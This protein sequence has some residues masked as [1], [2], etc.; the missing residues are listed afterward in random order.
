[1]DEDARYEICRF[2]LTVT[3]FFVDRDGPDS[4]KCGVKRRELYNDKMGKQTRFR[5]WLK[6]NFLEWRNK[7]MRKRIL[8]YLGVR[9]KKLEWILNRIWTKFI[10]LRISMGNVWGLVKTALDMQVSTNA[11]NLSTRW[12][13]LA[14]DKTTDIYII[15]ILFEYN[16]VQSGLLKQRRTVLQFVS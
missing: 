9:G 12:G 10:S 1:M 5:D 6:C 4:E 3:P 7:R 11:G 2:L 15:H 13:T 8:E 14:S 16:R